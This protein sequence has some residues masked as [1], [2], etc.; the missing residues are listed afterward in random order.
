MSVGSGWLRLESRTARLCCAGTVLVVSLATYL[1]TLAPTVTL[2]DSGELIVAARTLGVAHPP[3][4]PLYLL[5]AHL[6]T[7]IPIGS[8]AVRVNAASAVFAA[9]GSAALTL[10]VSEALLTARLVRARADQQK[11]DRRGKKPS[12]ANRS[13]RHESNILDLAAHPIGLVACLASG[14]L[15]AF[16]RTLWA[17]AT[18]AEVYTL[19]TLLI[20]G[21]FL[22]MLH[23][24]RLIILDAT[25]PP[26][27]NLASKHDRWLNV[28]AFLFGLGLGVHHVSVGLMLPALAWLVLATEGLAFFR[29]KRLFRAAIYSIAGLGIYAYLP[30]SA[31]HSP[32]V[33]WGDPQTF[34]RFWWHIT[35]RQY[36]V[37]FTFS[38]ERMGHELGEFARLVGSEFGPWFISVGLLSCFLGLVALF[39]RD[40]TAFWFL[41]LVI[42]CDVIYATSYQIA[43]DK[44]AYYLPAFVGMAVASSFV[45]EWLLTRELLATRFPIKTSVAAVSLILLLAPTLAFIG[46]LPF[47]NRS[48]YF[49]AHDYI[50]N[51]FNAIEPGGMLLT[52]DWQVYSPMIYV[53]EIERTRNDVVA[54]D[55]NQLRRSWYFDHLRRAYPAM[56]EQA[57][58]KVDAFLE[59]LTH[60]EQDPDLYQRDVT[61]NQRINSRFYEMIIAFVIDH[62]RQ[63]PVYVTQD[64]AINREGAD[65]ELTKWLSDTY[66][67]VPQGLV[68]QVAEKGAPVHLSESQLVTRGLA[69]GSVR[70]EVDDVVKV[71][72]IPVYVGMLYNR[73]RYLAATGRNQQAIE[74]FKAALDLQPNFLAA[75]QAIDEALNAQ[76]RSTTLDKAQ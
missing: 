54:I 70:F 19:N 35:G 65:A 50:E 20:T 69:D 11:P 38:S 3:G 7:L 58:D 33:N 67:F 56:I 62:L 18:I 59:D 21:I 60:W 40:R 46:N 22:L 2:V 73:G 45:G 64:L 4:F 31:S 39:K 52:R 68:F 43:E 26:A 30:L 17:Y 48:R 66:Q 75:Q 76:R 14:L 27:A 28:A 15:F 55:I 23:W 1:L 57:R 63:A 32:T 53:H 9:L 12:A 71:K 24:R 36:Q 51:I 6:A 5:L 13:K 49:I 8:V 29:G 72:V 25:R 41:G 16:S 37:F 42:A 47:N 10:V 61:L 74:S 44:D 34:Q